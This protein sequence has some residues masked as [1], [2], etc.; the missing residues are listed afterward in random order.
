[1]IQPA[2]CLPW[3]LEGLILIARPME[4]LSDVV[5]QDYKSSAEE[6]GDA[7]RSVGLTGQPI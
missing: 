5:S 6:T 7:G 4:K 1:M 2:K 3:K